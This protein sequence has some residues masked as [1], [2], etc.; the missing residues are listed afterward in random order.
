MPV[1]RACEMTGL[2]RAAYYKRSKPASERDADVIDVLNKIVE[3]HQRWGFWKCFSRLRLDG[4]QWNHKRV[5]RVYCH[6]GLNL[7]R[8]TKKRIPDRDRQPLDLAHK[9]NDCW[10][11]DFM[12]DSLYCGKAFR[13]LNVIDE[14]N[15][16]CLAIDIGTSIPSTR[17]IRT[18]ERLIDYYGKPQA[19]RL[20]N[21]PEMTSQQF[22]DWAQTRD[23]Y[24]RYIQPGKP[25][26]NAFIE[27][28]NRT[29][30]EEVL[31]AHLFDNIRQVQEITEQWL[32][33]YN[34]NRPH[35]SLGNIP[36]TQFM[37]RLTT[38]PILYNELST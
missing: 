22:M 9:V 17:L 10:A 18:L 25:N 24:I 19:I 2:S 6:M 27:R 31:S 16:E 11:L 38:A 13:T 30:R 21:G 3:N 29:Y 1:I 5:H 4:H 7:P 20:D 14:A 28:F 23:I 34:E 37:P 15:R 26:Q 12:H 33:E 36:P 32:Y 8:R 35:E